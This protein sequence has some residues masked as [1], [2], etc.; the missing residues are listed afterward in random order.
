MD[1]KNIKKRHVMSWDQ[2]NSKKDVLE[3]QTKEEKGSSKI[4]N[5]NYDHGSSKGGNKVLDKGMNKKT[6]GEPKGGSFNKGDVKDMSDTKKISEPKDESTIDKKGSKTNENNMAT[7]K[8]G[9]MDKAEKKSVGDDKSTLST[10]NK[11]K[12]DMAAEAGVSTKGQKKNPNVKYKSLAS[13]KKSV[14]ESK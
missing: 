13:K 1:Q 14:P 8:N 3:N 7:I 5:D 9:A 12:N 2:F 4:V 6:A 11:D 10:K